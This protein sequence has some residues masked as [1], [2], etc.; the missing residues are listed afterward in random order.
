MNLPPFMQ[1]IRTATVAKKYEVIAVGRCSQNISDQLIT[2]I[3]LIGLREQRHIKHR[4]QIAIP[5]HMCP[6]TL[7]EVCLGQFA[8]KDYAACSHVQFSRI[9]FAAT[10][11]SP[12]NAKLQLTGR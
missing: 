12:C 4:R 7:R 1:K 6:W 8:F 5:F 2:L 9:E 10:G 3:G 11:D